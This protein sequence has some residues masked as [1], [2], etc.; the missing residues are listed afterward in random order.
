MAINKD[1]ENF[2]AWAWRKE[3]RTHRLDFRDLS[4]AMYA[5]ALWA[6]WSEHRWPW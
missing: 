4:V 1:D 5:T 2:L 6:T 3:V